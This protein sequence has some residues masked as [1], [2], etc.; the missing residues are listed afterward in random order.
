[1]RL[2]I[3]RNSRNP[4]PVLNRPRHALGEGRARYGITAM[5]APDARSP[6]AA[7][8]PPDAPRNASPCRPQGPRHSRCKFPEA[9]DHMVRRRCLS[10]RFSLVA[11]LT[12][13]RIYRAGSGFGS[14][15]GASSSR[16]SKAGDRWSYLLTEIAAQAP[17]SVAQAPRSHR[18]AST[19]PPRNRQH[20]QRNPLAGITDGSSDQP[21]TH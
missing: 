10:Q 4:G 13:D 16:H 8:Q 11:R 2:Q 3:A 14:R 20:A 12:C 17:R 6:P 9:V 21:Y 18:V 19:R 15:Q 1:M 5:D 7:G